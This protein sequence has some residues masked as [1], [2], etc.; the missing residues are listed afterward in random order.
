M[1]GSWNGGRQGASECSSFSSTFSSAGLYFSFRVIS[2]RHE[3]RTPRSLRTLPS[4]R[5]E[6]KLRNSCPYL[7]QLAECSAV[8]VQT[9]K[10]RWF[11]SGSREL[12]MFSGPHLTMRIAFDRVKIVD[13]SPWQS[14]QQLSPLLREHSNFCDEVAAQKEMYYKNLSES[15]LMETLSLGLQ[16]NGIR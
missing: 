1:F 9:P 10:G 4:I 2:D 14:A 11:N 16:N 12:F 8:E 5:P 13:C 7:T 3:T 15:T 6:L